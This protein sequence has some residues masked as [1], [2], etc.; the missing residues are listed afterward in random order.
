MA[1]ETPKE[2]S[3]FKNELIR[4]R[5]ECDKLM[6]E[7]SALLGPDWY[8]EEFTKENSSAD[9]D[10]MKSHLMLAVRQADEWRRS[11]GIVLKALEGTE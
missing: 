11:L 3:K 9:V 6:R 7:T 4:L 10:L 1:E 8:T 2:I 5:G